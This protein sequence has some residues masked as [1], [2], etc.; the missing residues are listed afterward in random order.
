[1][2]EEYDFVTVEEGEGH[3]FGVGQV[4]HVSKDYCS[5]TFFDSPEKKHCKNDND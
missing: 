4:T 1:M 3:L 2:F 5:I